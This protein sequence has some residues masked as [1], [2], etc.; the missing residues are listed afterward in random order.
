MK[1]PSRGRQ[2]RIGLVVEGTTEYRAIPAI[3]G[4][5]QIETTAPSCF[6]G[7]AQGSS[8]KDLVRHRILK[9]VLAQLAKGPEKVIVVLDT[10]GRSG[11]AERFRVALL[12]ELRNQVKRCEGGSA[13]ALIEVIPCIPR[14]EN[15]LISDP[16]GIRR[17][18]YIRKDLSAKVNCHADGKDAL[19][20]LKDAFRKDEAYNKALH[21]PRI[22]Q[23]LRV[24][25]PNV[26]QC[27]KSLREFLQIAGDV[28]RKT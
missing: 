7:Q 21:G 3:L 4:L 27:S 25:D 22:A 5:L 11:P 28:A 23:F 24:G 12:K 26:R 9:D 1:V 6:H 10:E 18:R 8:I 13:P 20:I 16:S 2:P 15:W 17:C 19:A 14:F